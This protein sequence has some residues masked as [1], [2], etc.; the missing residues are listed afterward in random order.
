VGN[1]F[2]FGG[3]THRITRHSQEQFD[4]SNQR[5]DTNRF[6]LITIGQGVITDIRQE[7]PDEGDPYLACKLAA[8]H[9]LTDEVEKCYFNIKV[10]GTDAE[11]LIRRCEKAGNDPHRTVLIGFRLA[12]LWLDQPDQSEAE[13]QPDQRKIPLRARL[14]EITGIRVDDEPVYGV[15]PGPRESQGKKYYDLHSFGLG[16]VNRLRKVTPRRADPFYSCD[17]AAMHGPNDEVQYCRIDTKIVSQDVE[18]LLRGHED[19]IHRNDTRLL[20]KFRVG[21]LWID[22][23]TY[24]TNH[25]DPERAGKLGVVL[26][27]R[28]FNIPW[29]KASRASGPASHQ[30]DPPPAD[31]E[32]KVDHEVASHG[33]G[34]PANKEEYQADEVTA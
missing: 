3:I 6:D 17:I 12:G 25:T 19:T 22:Y 30:N 4:M 20:V 29:S 27:G 13:L 14:T 1:T 34:I 11:H 31:A 15:I 5:S 7:C 16:Y 24:A 8:Y 10:V 2:E 9:G 18:Q 33:P 28:L 26:K 32:S 23:F 21:D